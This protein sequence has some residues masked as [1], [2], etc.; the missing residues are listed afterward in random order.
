MVTR[1]LTEQEAVALDLEEGSA[2]DYDTLLFTS[3]DD[4]SVFNYDRSSVE[5]LDE[6]LGRDGKMNTLLQVLT[7]PMR[8]AP[9]SFRRGQAE[10]KVTDWLAQVMTEPANNGGMT[11]PLKTIIAQMTGAIAYR[12]AFFEKVFTLGEDDRIVYKKVAWRPPATCAVMRDP[13]NGAFR[14]FKQQPIRLEDN[15]EITIPHKRAFVYIHGQHR[16]PLEG[17]SD[18]DIP[19]WCYITKQ[20]IRFL[21][22]SFLEGQSLPKTVVTARDET[23][24]NKAAAKVVG[25]RQGGVV[26]LAEGVTTDVLES[27]GRGAAQFKEALQW[28]DAEAS[29]SVLAGFTDLGA[30]ATS[31]IGSFALSK[32]QTDFFL[33]SRQAVSQ[34]MADTINQFLI[35][36]LVRMNF[37]P[38]TRSPIMEFSPISE[39]DAQMAVSLLQATA[40]SPSLVLPREFMDELTERVAGFLGLN[41]ARVREGLARAAVESAKKAETTVQ[42]AIPGARVSPEL[43]QRAGNVG[44]VMGAVNAATN[45]VVNKRIQ[46]ANT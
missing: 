8:Q 27:S 24:A 39:D 33:M 20:K 17:V 26:G 25:L 38:K 42:P 10:A 9:I 7:L 23:S 12:K 21:W 28:L 34:E 11:T 43:Q 30:A 19:Y 29:G 1:A 37:G 5:R 22:Y 36:D 2:F 44:T 35:P 31:G 46:Q 18:L 15:D 4:G 13:Q 14:G 6:A 32:D 3:F 16:N 45:A 41:T 40:Q